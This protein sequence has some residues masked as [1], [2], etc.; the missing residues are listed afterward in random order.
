VRSFP[1][2]APPPRRGVR[3]ASEARVA[4]GDSEKRSACREE[5]SP[6]SRASERAAGERRRE[7]RRGVSIGR[8]GK[9]EAGSGKREAGSGKRGAARACMRR[10]VG[11]QTRLLRSYAEIKFCGLL[12]RAK[13]DAR[14]ALSMPASRRERCGRLPPPPLLPCRSLIVTT[15]LAWEARVRARGEK[16]ERAT[17]RSR[18]P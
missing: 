12:Y 5:C 15:S 2:F 3:D 18:A 14:V 6:P 10:I 11:E 13:C 9:R 8:D 7:G 4:Y 1:S 17:T 16:V